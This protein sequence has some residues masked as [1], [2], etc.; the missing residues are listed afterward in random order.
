MRS[1]LNNPE[2]IIIDTEKI[3]N[4]FNKIIKTI[5]FRYKIGPVVEAINSEII[6]S[7]NSKYDLIWVDKGIFITEET[8]KKLKDKT[9]KLIHYTPDTAFY[10]NKSYHFYNSIKL[11][12]ACITTKSFDLVLYKKFFA[13]KIIYCTQGYDKN[14]HKTYNCFPDKSGI[15]FI[16][17]YEINRDIF[18]QK[19][20]DAG[21][22]IKL[23]GVKWDSFVRRNKNKSN[24]FFFGKSVFGEEYGKLISSSLFGLGFLSKKFPELHTTRTFEIPACKTIL[25]T[26]RNEETR[27]F[28]KDDE[29]VFYNTSEEL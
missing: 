18:I 23:A 11:Y 16:G 21:L 6:K 20:L 29:V 24:L 25:I 12:D 28:F 2:F 10:E 8:T 9:E 14:I 19:L 7:L 5:G 15:C 27:K 22:E 3:L 1:L 17:L 26:E 13:K 4:S